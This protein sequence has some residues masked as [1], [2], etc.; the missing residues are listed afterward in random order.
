MFCGLF[1]TTQEANNIFLPFKFSINFALTVLKSITDFSFSVLCEI[2]GIAFR[3]IEL[4]SHLY[5]L[6]SCVFSFLSCMWCTSY[7]YV[8][9][10]SF[11]LWEFLI[12]PS[13]WTVSLYILTIVP[14]AQDENLLTLVLTIATNMGI[15]NLKTE[16]CVCIYI[17]DKYIY[18]YIYIWFTFLYSRKLVQYCNQLLQ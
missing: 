17:C 9:K 7:T 2:L 14:W 1:F 10:H 11:T 4:S 15:R 3:M 16:E 12:F 6:W 13:E 5:K 18:V 8:W